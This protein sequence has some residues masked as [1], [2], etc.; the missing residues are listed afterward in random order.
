MSSPYAI[1]PGGA[2][3]FKSGHKRKAKSST[4]NSVRQHA[5]KRGAVELNDTHGPSSSSG[6][7][8][9]STDHPHEQLPRSRS[10]DTLP[11]TAPPDDP[12]P[13]MT[14]AERELVNVRRKRVCIDTLTSWAMSL[15]KR[16]AKH[17]KTVS[18]S[19]TST[20]IR[21]LNS[22]TCRVWRALNS[23]AALH[24]GKHSLTPC[25][26]TI[27]RTLLCLFSACWR[28]LVSGIDVRWLA[29]SHEE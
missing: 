5:D 4:S 28:R 23:Y 14:K 12:L 8:N 29:H 6:R 13:Y 18:M 21:C 11:I 19:L 22:T 15:K 16:H 25:V 3:K 1:R 26:R 17:T 9:N 20:S 7:N 24:V 27:L 10:R 2:L